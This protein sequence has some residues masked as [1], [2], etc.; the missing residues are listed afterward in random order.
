MSVKEKTQIPHNFTKEIRWV[1]GA[2]ED[3]GVDLTN[4]FQKDCIQN[5]V[6]A[7]KVNSWNNW[8]CDIY[9][10]SNSKGIFLIIED[11]GTLGL[12]GPNLPVS[13]IKEIMDKD[14]E[15]KNDHRLARFSSMHNSGGNETG[16]GSYGVGKIIYSVASNDGKYYFDSFT[17]ENKY[18]ANSV[19]KGNIFE[20]SFEGEEAINFIKSETGIDKKSEP[21]TRVIICNPK[22][23]LIDSFENGNLVKYIQETWWRIIDRIED[24][25]LG[26]FINHNR[27]TFPN[28][29]KVVKKYILEKPEIFKTGYRVKHFGFYINDQTDQTWNNISY[30]RKGMKIGTVDLADIPEG[31]KGKYWG[32]IEV[33]DE[34]EREL[35]LIEDKVHFGVSKGKKNKQAYQYL[36]NYVS[37]KVRKLLIEWKYIKDKEAEDLKLKKQLDSIAEEIQNLFDSLGFEDLGKG[38]KKPDYIIRWQ[39]VKFPVSGCNEVEVN[40]EVSFD[41]KIT[42]NYLGKRKFKY[43]LKILR[44][45]DNSIFD[46]EKET[47]ELEPNQELKRTYKFKIDEVNSLRFSEN[48]IILRVDAVG[49]SLTKEKEISYFFDM[50]RPDNTREEVRLTL[51][52]CGFPREKS[53]RVNFNECLTEIVYRVEN[54][55][56]ETLDYKLNISIHD[57]RE[58]TYPKILDVVSCN[59]RVDYYEESFI[60]IP[61]IVFKEEI[62]NK[63]ITKGELELRARL[64][65]LNGNNIYEKG[66]KIT[67]YNFKIFLNVDEKNGKVDSFKP[68]NIDLPEDSRRSW[69]EINGMEKII[70]LNT[71]HL[72]YKFIS[73]NLEL[74][75]IYIREQ[76]IKQYV[77]LYLYEQKFNMF[78]ENGKGIED[79]D[80]IESNRIIDKKIENI[81]ALSYK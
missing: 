2:Y 69:Y 59:G 29:P 77:Y 54:K 20:T 80:V 40:D 79:M 19:D 44:K 63:I 38:P 53:R 71:A 72:A 49:S 58:K 21:G 31:I 41:F 60:N 33:D 1:F 34:W 14:G 12:I 57:A 16:A 42:S 5:C 55:C 28:F 74:Q 67:T 15:L 66:E 10:I 46:L 50:V 37:E 9:L 7:R 70:C 36:K 6:G 30:F 35:E 4:G 25:N 17:L 65:A 62:Y 52:N 48:K 56:T 32:Y 78:T 26:I 81:L 61:D 18:V 51:N 76:M 45:N 43:S 27:V 47:F 73:D 22:K 75:R 13:K 8:K 64:I 23:E 68:R 24:K 11:F 39:N 3:A